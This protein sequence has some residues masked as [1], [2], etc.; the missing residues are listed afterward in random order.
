MEENGNRL[1]FPFNGQRKKI[2]L[3][4]GAKLRDFEGAAKF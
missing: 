1:R 4:S 2:V 3:Y